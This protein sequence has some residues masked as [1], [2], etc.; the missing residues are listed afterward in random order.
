M[1]ELKILPKRCTVMKA[2]K[3]L[4]DML[5]DRKVIHFIREGRRI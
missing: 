1:Y 3:D 5:V 4:E 2:D